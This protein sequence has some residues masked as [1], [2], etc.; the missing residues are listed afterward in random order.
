MAWNYAQW[1][2]KKQ[3][4]PNVLIFS[5]F[6]FLTS[7][8]IGYKWFYQPWRRR[9]QMEEYNQYAKFIYESEVNRQNNK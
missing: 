9:L 7:G 8:V 3:G 4:N 6:C 5:V 1:A 2:K